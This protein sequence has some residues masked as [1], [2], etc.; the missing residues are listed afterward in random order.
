MDIQQ[1][2]TEHAIHINI[3]PAYGGPLTQVGG[4]IY[5]VGCGLFG[6]TRALVKA[7]VPHLK[8]AG[9]AFYDASGNI[10]HAAVP[11]V[12][13]VAAKTSNTVQHIALRTG[14]LRRTQSY[15]DIEAQDGWYLVDAEGV[16]TPADFTSIEIENDDPE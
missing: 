5:A 14:V 10:L 9:G 6:I 1:F 13:T 15:S 16:A 4:G 12:E 3:P 2:P 8:A 7:T 11:Y